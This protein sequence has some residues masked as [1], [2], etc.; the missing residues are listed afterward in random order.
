MKLFQWKDK[1]TEMCEIL[2]VFFLLDFCVAQGNKLNK[3]RLSRGKN[4]VKDEAIR[5]K[6]REYKIQK[7]AET[8]RPKL[9]KTITNIEKHTR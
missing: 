3:D 2:W 1:I 7:C 6:G 8:T 4:G 9:G 5:F